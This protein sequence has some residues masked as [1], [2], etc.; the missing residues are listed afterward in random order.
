[1]KKHILWTL[2]GLGVASA[3]VALIFL[4]V[5]LALAYVRWAVEFFGPFSWKALAATLGPILVPAMLYFAHDL[6]KFLAGKEGKHG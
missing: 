2:R 5:W 6:G 1:M 3:I 4:A